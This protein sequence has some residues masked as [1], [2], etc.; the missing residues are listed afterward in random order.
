[1]EMFALTVTIP[2]TVIEGTKCLMVRALV[3]MVAAI[4]FRVVLLKVTFALTF[5][6]T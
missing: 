5:C 6:L 1:M 4:Y 3:I 2:G